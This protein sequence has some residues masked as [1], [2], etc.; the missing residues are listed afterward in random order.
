MA[1][2]TGKAFLSHDL[3]V[4]ILAA[5]NEGEVTV[6]QFAIRNKVPRER[7]YYHF[8]ALLKAG[9]LN[10]REVQRRGVRMHLYWAA[11]KPIITDPE[12]RRPGHEGAP[13][14]QRD[15]HPGFLQSL[16][17]RVEGRNL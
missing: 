7:A 8:R 17:G 1:E 5:C 6:E 11:Q 4:R 14:T 9:F 12:F 13:P 15:R 3:R 2:P 16:L 10:R